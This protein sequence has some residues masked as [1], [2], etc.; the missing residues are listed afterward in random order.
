[1]SPD[2]Q[3][4][5]DA[6]LFAFVW[7]FPSPEQAFSRQWKAATNRVPTR[8]VEVL[9]LKVVVTKKGGITRLKRF[10]VDSNPCVPFLR[11]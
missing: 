11:Q 10:N 4:H 8:L 3:R 5:R 9:S 1:M 6:R 2:S 7:L